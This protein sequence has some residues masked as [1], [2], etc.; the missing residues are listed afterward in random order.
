MYANEHTAIV[1]VTVTAHILSKAWLRSAMISST[2]SMPTLRR[3]RSSV[4]SPCNLRICMRSHFNMCIAFYT[5]T[6][7]LQFVC[8]VALQPEDIRDHP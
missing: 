4:M 7:T 8:D 1:T 2:S 3:T 6:E 5:D